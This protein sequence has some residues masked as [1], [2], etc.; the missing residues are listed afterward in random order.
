MIIDRTVMDLCDIVTVGFYTKNEHI[1]RKINDTTFLRIVRLNDHIAEMYFTDGG[2]DRIHVPNGL[3]V[4][5]S[6]TMKKIPFYH[7]TQSFALSWSQSYT[8]YAWRYDEMNKP[9]YVTHKFSSTTYYR[10]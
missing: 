2:E 5:N 9:T 10:E 3:M 7:N 8:V 4:F 1:Q 6:I